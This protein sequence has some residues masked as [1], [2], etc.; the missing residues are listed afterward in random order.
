MPAQTEIS[1][2]LIFYFEH[3]LSVIPLFAAKKLW[4]LENMPQ[5]L[6]SLST[7][8]YQKHE[9]YRASFPAASK[10]EKNNFLVVLLASLG[11]LDSE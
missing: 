3:Q 10:K 9:A 11:W 8:S 1:R 4:H 7:S 2:A 6:R 5:R